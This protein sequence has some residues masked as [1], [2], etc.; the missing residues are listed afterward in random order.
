MRERL[1]LLLVAGLTAGLSAEDWPAWRGP[2]GDGTSQETQVPLHWSAQ[3][4]IAWKAPVPGRGHSSPIVWGERVFV[5]SCLE[6]Q[7]QRLLLCFERRTGRL[8]WQR[9]VLTSPLEP[10]HRLNSYASST[11]ATD[12]QFVWTSFLRLRPRTPADEPPRHLREPTPI[13]EHLIPEM[14]VTCFT[15]HGERVWEA[16]PGRFYSRHGYCSPPILYRDLVLLNGDQDAEAYLVALDKHTGRQRWRAARPNRTRSYCAPLLL[17]VAGRTQLILSGSLSITAYDAAN[18]QL[19]WYVEGPTEQFVASPVH[20]Q[21]IVFVTA[22]YPDYHNIAIRPT[23]RGNVTHTHV[24]WH[25]KKVPARKAAY[26][27]SPIAQGPYFFLVSD[28]GYARCL[29]AKTGRQLWLERLGNHHSASPIAAAGYLYFVA[30]EGTTYVLKASPT[31]TLVARNP[32]GE[33]CY[34]SPAL[35]DGHLFLRSTQHLWCIGPPFSSHAP[36]ASQSASPAPPADR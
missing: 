28:T 16:V 29:E 30:D 1:T 11:P 15:V 7:G 8:L 14:V 32:L 22:G 34:A 36:A 5:T 26:V 27:P 3:K 6:E 21:G 17:E 25:E 23:G 31:F 35:A 13:P 2:R 12:G 33:E 18:G 19:L 10:K 9:V 20:T 4:N 24:L